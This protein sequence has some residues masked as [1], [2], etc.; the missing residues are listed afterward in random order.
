[1]KQDIT[2][3]HCD[4]VPE[5]TGAVDK[6]FQGYASIQFMMS[7]SVYLSYDGRR[8][9]LDGPWVWC[10]WPGPHTVFHVAKGQSHWDHRYIA[11]R[12]SKVEVWLADGLLPDSPVPVGRLAALSQDFDRIITFARRSDSLGRNIAEQLT[13]AMLMILKDG[14]YGPHESDNFLAT[15]DEWLFQNRFGRP[16]YESLASQLG[17]GESTLRRKFRQN[18][19]QSLH[20]RFLAIRIEAA[21]ALISDRSIPIKE[22]AHMLGFNDVYYFSKQ[23]RKL[24]GVPPAAFRRSIQYDMQPSN[25]AAV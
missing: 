7:G 22:I 4:H 19:G 17:M 23:F 25:R 12:G 8:H 20:A 15:V 2:F 21:R 13:D 14:G 10:A 6:V 5:C 11:F 24:V 1:M 18:A 9:D 3:L 16:D